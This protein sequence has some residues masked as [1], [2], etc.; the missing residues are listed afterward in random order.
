MPHS[1]SLS[2]KASRRILVVDDE[3][4]ILAVVKRVLQKDHALELEPSPV[5]ALERIVQGERFDLVLC[6][7]T[8]PDLSGPELYARVQEHDPAQAGRMVF[9][10]GGAFTED[11]Q[12]FLKA[13]PLP[14]LEKPFEP[15]ALRELVRAACGQ[16]TR[17]G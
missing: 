14:V 4:L 2:P 5:R 15:H 7:L 1:Q 8:M 6:D 3:P 17:L 11:A 13:H 9:L 10:T 16:P 12:S